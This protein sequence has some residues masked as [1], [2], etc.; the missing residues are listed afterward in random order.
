MTPELSVVVL[1]YK[2]RET[3]ID[4]VARLKDALSA[5]TS[6]WELVL[7]GNYNKGD[8]T[9]TTPE[10]VRKLA[11]EDSRVVAV[12]LEKQGWMGWDAR[13]GLE[14]ARGRYIAFIDG[15]NQMP[16]EDVVR[17]FTTLRESDYD[18]V[19][20]YRVQ[21]GDGPF[22]MF[23]SLGYNLIFN[24]L[25]PG[26]GVRDVNSKPKIFRRELFDKLKLTSDDW[27]LDAEIVIQVRRL[28]A[29]VG[30]IPTVFRSSE[31]RSSMVK[32]TAIWEFVKNLLRARLREFTGR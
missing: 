25:F 1:C 8:T 2:A 27:F 30:Q 18:M 22:R 20:T 23:Q 3:A 4:F 16:P 14:R 17:V 13:T 11:A 7:V 5:V 19:T 28:K 29:R 21:R 31:A 32:L 15:D 10:V 24:C 6:D 26:S 12:T 9:D